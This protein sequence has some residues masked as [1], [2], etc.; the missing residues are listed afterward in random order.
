M[1]ERSSV[2]AG[3]PRI[4]LVPEM[5]D[6]PSLVNIK[7]S[8]EI[9][10]VAPGSMRWLV[11]GAIAVALV[12]AA[13]WLGY[14]V[15][16]Q[17]GL[18]HLRAAAQQ[19]LAVEA[20]RLDGHLSR[21]E[22]LPSLLE[23][24]PSVFRLL[25]APS[26]SALRQTVSEYLK[27]INLLAGAENLY[28]LGVS[29]DTL[30]AAD[31]EQPGTPFGQNLSYRPYVSEALSK[32][33]GAF[34]GVGITSARAGY[35]LS[36]A[37]K[38]GGETRGVATVKVNLDSFE[39]GWRDIESDILLLDERR[40]AILS[41]RDAWRFRPMAPLSHQMHDE[42]SRSKPYGNHELMPLGWTF[43]AQDGAARITAENGAAYTLSER[44][45]NNGL[46][47][48]V[49]L[50]DEA[51]TRQTALIIGAMSG[52]ACIAALLAAGLVVQRRRAI[53]QRLANQAALQ[54]ANDMLEIRVQERTAELR[55]AQDDLIHAGKLAALGQMSAGIVHEL[56]QPLAAL[57][58]AADNAIVLVDRGSIGEARGNLTRIGELVRRLGRLTGQLRI[59][60]YKSSSPLDAVSVEHAVAESLKILAG[61]VKEGE[62]TVVTDVDA[63]IRVVADQT[64]LEQLLCNIVANALDA[65]ESADRKS[66]LIRASREEGQTA[67]CR[68]VIS[69]SG[70]AIAPDVL[71]RMFEPFVTTKPAGKGLGLGLMLS[72]HIAHSFGGELRARNLTPCGAEFAVTLPLAVTSEVSHGR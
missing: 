27:S 68:I 63:N 39:H 11:R 17:R 52:L 22:Y 12:V 67:R 51:P 4:C 31:F 14:A 55:A 47:K 37:L 21:F 8:P 29:G 70:P 10:S 15:A 6:L 64:R 65:V 16:F 20:V 35:Y 23:T 54:A 56:N 57:Q 7:G 38:D 34:F 13:S 33:R 58:T 62:V 50:D 25:G 30:A 42:I 28:V 5:T 53:K 3:A 36:Y 61:R 19:R 44:P 43:V 71:Q 2:V 24:S 46:W 60:A 72:N 69:N 45:I 66:I 49:L 40:V 59:F 9:S 1:H 48:L 41:S 32:G 26:D 18:E